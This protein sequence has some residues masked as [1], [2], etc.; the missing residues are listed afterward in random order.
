MTAIRYI[1]ALSLVACSAAVAGT[2]KA[3]GID[4]VVIFGA[5]GRIGRHIVDE[6]LHRGYRVTGVTRDPARLEDYADRIAIATADILDR[7]QVADL[8]D[9]SDAV[10]VS[11]GGPPAN[12]HPAQYIAA[13]AADSLI[14][15]LQS[16]GDEGPRLVFVG[17]LFTL[18]YED[19]KSLLEL[20]RV[21]DDH[22]NYA[23]F[24]GHRIALERFR[25]SQHVNWTVATP[26][27][28][29]R[30]EGRTGKIRWGGD[31]LLRDPDGKPSGISP[32]DFA[33][34]IFEELAS[35]NYIRKRFNVAR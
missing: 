29:L 30:L 18:E 32:Q 25:A 34:A 9:E 6:A 17:N 2:G 24:H 4:N 7:E 1:V 14:D 11:V 5:S 16:R 35:G 33:Y 27:N 31:T 10:I 23:M 21:P 20:G 8:I 28:G 26:P 13:T 22:E 19:G 12:Q 3:P 15:V